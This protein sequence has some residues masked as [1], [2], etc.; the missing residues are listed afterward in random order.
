MSKLHD[1][2][3]ERKEQMLVLCDKQGNYIGEATREVCHK[4]KGK[5]HLAFLAFIVDSDGKVILTQRGKK[6]S[7]WAGY[8]DASVVSHV[9]S[10]ETPLTAANR[11]GKEELGVEVA[12]E[13]LG[14]FY[15]FSPHGK[16]AENEY[17]YV[18]LGTTLSEVSPNPVEISDIKRTSFSDL[19]SESKNQ[20]GKYTPWL[21]LSLSKIDALKRL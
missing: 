9:L 21:L 16:S 3:G 17:C 18:L 5:L 10:G 12:F 6:K 11:R 14:G 2:R 13:L 7:L 8:W 15:Y 1:I 4:G 20:R 19:Y